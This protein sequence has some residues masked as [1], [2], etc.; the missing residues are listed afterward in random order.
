[1]LTEQE[2]LWNGRS[3]GCG[4]LTTSQRKRTW[5]PS[6]DS[7]PG[8]LQHSQ[9]GHSSESP[10]EAGSLILGEH[11]Q[12]WGE[13]SLKNER[14]IP[15]NFQGWPQALEQ[16][17]L[18]RDATLTVFHTL[19][20]FS[21]NWKAPCMIP[22]LTYKLKANVPFVQQTLPPLSDTGVVCDLYRRETKTDSK[23]NKSMLLPLTD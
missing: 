2:T 16:V 3:C 22:G 23:Q 1:M 14:K 17:A 9:T 15:V 11:C 7:N 10:G 12:V 18:N 4:N 21:L 6:A 8:Q 20:C 19:N 5:V 13:L